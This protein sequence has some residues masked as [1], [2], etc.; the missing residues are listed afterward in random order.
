MEFRVLAQL[1]L[2]TYQEAT[3]P[4]CCQGCSGSKPVS[5]SFVQGY[6]HVWNEY[7]FAA[8]KILC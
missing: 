4:A 8:L 3:L 5:A 6:F 2:Y 7:E 1:R